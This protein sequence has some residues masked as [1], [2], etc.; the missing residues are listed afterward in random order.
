MP[1]GK[2]GMRYGAVSAKTERKKTRQQIKR[3]LRLRG[4][5][6]AEKRA[7]LV[8][9]EGVTLARNGPSRLSLMTGG[10]HSSDERMRYADNPT[11]EITL[12]V[13]R[14]LDSLGLPRVLMWLSRPSATDRRTAQKQLV[15]EVTNSTADPD[16][17]RR[18]YRIPVHPR[19]CPLLDG[20]T[21]GAPQ[22][23]TALNA[24]ASTYGLRGEEYVLVTET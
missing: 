3:T 5:V 23:L 18:K 15:V 20:G 17:T 14:D 10:W 7:S 19:L 21:L 8:L 24:I 2:L 1:R 9:K 12:V 4:S 22:K 11:I 16:G 6:V 13:G